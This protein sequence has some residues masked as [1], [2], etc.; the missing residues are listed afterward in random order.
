[1][2]II[3]PSISSP[4]P[5]HDHRYNIITSSPFFPAAAT[6]SPYHNLHLQPPSTTADTTPLPQPPSPFHHTTAPTTPPPAAI[7][8]KKVPA[9]RVRLCGLAATAGPFG[10]VTD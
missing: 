8:T 5:Q 6:T 4:Q 3:N 10:S 7:T 2:H 9:A 1:M